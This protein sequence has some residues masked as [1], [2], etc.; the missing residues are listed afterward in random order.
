[1]GMKMVEAKPAARVTVSRARSRPSRNHETT[2]A[3]AGS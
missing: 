3:K 1:M 2:T